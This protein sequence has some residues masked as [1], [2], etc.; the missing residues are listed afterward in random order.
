MSFRLVSLDMAGTTF[1]DG[2]AVYEVLSDTVSQA[3][4]REVP[5]ELLDRWTG[6][7]KRAAIEGLLRAFGSDLETDTVYERFTKSLMTHYRNDPP[8]PF[9]GVTEMFA[10]LHDEG[11]KVALQTGYSVPVAEMLLQS[12][13][14][15]VGT[16][17]DAFVSSDEVTASR[18][19]PYLIFHTME[20]TGVVDVRNVLV[21]GDTPNDL[22]AGTRA[23]AGYVV[24]VLSGAH[25]H[26][27]LGRT[28]HTHLIPSV[29]DILSL[30]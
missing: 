6:T 18:P 7:S 16:H 30:R 11:V 1:D 23:G 13:G 27:V 20:K 9:P 21:A 26:H 24:G 28:P 22:L 2:N 14:W 3:I 17:I 10:Q 15:Q 5:Q 8:A 12:A 4:N 25:D 29:T 19:A